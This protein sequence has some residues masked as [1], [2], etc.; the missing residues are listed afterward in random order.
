[1]KKDQLFI[2]VLAC[3]GLIIIAGSVIADALTFKPINYRDPCYKYKVYA[4]KTNQTK[5]RMQVIYCMLIVTKFN[6]ST[7][8]YNISTLSTI[9]IKNGI[10]RTN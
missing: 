10:I 1:M 5:D 9:K 8:I 7:N 4:N 6:K 2:V 3:I